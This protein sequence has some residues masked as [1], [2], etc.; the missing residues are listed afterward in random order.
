MPR[1]PCTQSDRS[2]L[3][4]CATSALA[5]GIM[6]C[7]VSSTYSFVPGVLPG[8]N[9]PLRFP[10]VCDLLTI[11][12]Q[13][14]EV[15]QLITKDA[16]AKVH[17]S[18]PSGGDPVKFAPRLVMEI[19]DSNAQT[20]YNQQSHAMHFDNAY[21][22]QGGQRLIKGKED[23]LKQL[24]Q[25]STL[26]AS[27]AQTL[28]ILLGKYLHT[29]QDF[30][31]HS[32]YVNLA[33]R[34]SIQ[35]GDGL[36]PSQPD[37]TRA[38]VGG[39]PPGNT[40]QLMPLFL[41][42]LMTTGWAIDPLQLA[43]APDDQC[44]HGLVGNGIHKDWSGRNRHGDAR[45]LAT[46]ATYEFVNSIVSNSSITNKDNVC[47]FMSDKP[48]QKSTVTCP[49]NNPNI[50]AFV[51]IGGYH[52][53]DSKGIESPTG[54]V[55]VSNDLASATAGGRKGDASVTFSASMVNR[56][57]SGGRA[58]VNYSDSFK[59]TS[60]SKALGSKG[61]AILSVSGGASASGTCQYDSTSQ[62][63]DPV[64]TSAAVTLWDRRT[65]SIGYEARFNCPDTIPAP[66]MP[67]SATLSFDYGQTIGFEVIVAAAGKFQGPP[68]G[69]STSGSTT[70]SANVSYNVSV[71]NDPDAVVTWCRT[72]SQ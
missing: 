63:A 17:F 39:P 2:L 25:P 61:T 51:T 15:H 29:L 3:R 52:G 16:L 7:A 46:T 5:V 57:G 19:E 34:P 70:G 33:V 9:C 65:F 37:N 6:V 10:A 28:R 72:P 14:E 54:S 43:D 21:L 8:V 35:L 64:S 58:S 26:T 20:D 62:S 41:E 60:S 71:Q 40:T 59:I 56:E 69:P 36:P 18:P 48:C 4:V 22:K 50:S 53:G 13:Y 42:D 11:L 47:V 12:P 55:S 45:T 27:Q 68:W 66:F 44:A 67:T 24:Q 38:C 32:N 49:D 31:A 1:T 30:Y 23:L